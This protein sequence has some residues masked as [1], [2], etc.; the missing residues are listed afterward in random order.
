MIIRKVDK[1]GRV[2]LPINYRKAL[3]IK[4]NGEVAL[5]I[6]GNTITIK[7]QN[8]ICKL[9]G[10]DCSIIQ[11]IGICEKCTKRIKKFY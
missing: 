10:T 5:E 6:K 3:K 8:E 9:C 4:D 7:R 11:D 2:V 1:M